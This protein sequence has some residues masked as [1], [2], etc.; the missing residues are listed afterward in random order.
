MGTGVPTSGNG[1]HLPHYQQSYR[2]LQTIPFHLMNAQI[3]PNL[4][5][6]KKLNLIPTIP[7]PKY[8]KMQNE[9]YIKIE[10]ILY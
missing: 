8:I 4:P 7:N 9:K 10:T 5:I 3:H 6:D 2:M 1:S